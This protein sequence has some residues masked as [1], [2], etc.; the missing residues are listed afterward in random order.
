MKITV[1][2]NL[3]FCIRIKSSA[4]YSFNRKSVFFLHAHAT[5]IVKHEINMEGIFALVF[6]AETAL[7]LYVSEI[8]FAVAVAP[9]MADLYTKPT[10]LWSRNIIL[11]YKHV[12]RF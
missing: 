12:P 4:V 3:I 5:A 6:P 2:V 8:R 10:L 1:E 9:T 11:L 7:R